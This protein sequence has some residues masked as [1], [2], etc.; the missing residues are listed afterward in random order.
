MMPDGK[1]VLLKWISGDV[2]EVHELAFAVHD[3]VDG[4]DGAPGPQGEP[5]RDGKDG[6]DGQPGIPGRDGKDGL[7]GKDGV[8][9][10]DG[11]GYD[12]LDVKLE[13]GGR[14]R[15]ER[16]LKDGA[17]VKEFRLK[18][19]TPIYRG[20]WEEKVWDQGDI[21]FWGGSM[22]CALSDTKSKPDVSKDW[23]L[24]VRR[25]RDGKNGKDGDRGPQ[26]AKGEKGDIGPRGIPA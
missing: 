7:N 21:V 8:P 13:D 1:T 15:I 16:Y 12:D 20:V 22:F 19:A 6:R 17:L 25:G 10:R 4:K 11:V 24:C 5:G 18:L 23:A 9:G 3:G 2:E 26:G 14:W